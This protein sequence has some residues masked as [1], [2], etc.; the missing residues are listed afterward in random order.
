MK[1]SR[2]AVLALLAL[3]AALAV[4][5]AAKAAKAQHRVTQT[6][7]PVEMSSMA[8][9]FYN[10]GECGGAGWVRARR[11]ASRQLGAIFEPARAVSPRQPAGAA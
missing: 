6:G 7:G 11:G 2:G 4:S 1:A 10:S 9:T 8:I 3:G 5:Q